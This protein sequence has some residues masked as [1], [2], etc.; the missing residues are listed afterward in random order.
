MCLTNHIK[1]FPRLKGLVHPL[2]IRYLIVRKPISKKLSTFIAVINYLF[3][4][5]AFSI[6]SGDGSYPVTA[7]IAYFVYR[8]LNKG[9]EEKNKGN[10]LDVN[11]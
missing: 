8:I 7:I 4:I 5:I 1:T 10:L 2:L 3:N 11:L 6:V 9:Y